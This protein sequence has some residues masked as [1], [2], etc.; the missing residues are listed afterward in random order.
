MCVCFKSK[1]GETFVFCLPEYY[2]DTTWHLNVSTTVGGCVV[3]GKV[4][5]S[6]LIKNPLKGFQQ[7]EPP[8]ARRIYL[9]RV[10]LSKSQPLKDSCHCCQGSKVKRFKYSWIMSQ[11]IIY[12]YFSCTHRFA[13]LLRTR[14]TAVNDSDSKL[15]IV[16]F[17]DFSGERNRNNRPDKRQLDI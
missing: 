11:W 10:L 13:S 16:H 5:A 3:R 9:F 15:I 7:R 1:I 8:P 12:G 14:M 2:F 4:P 17:R 6:V